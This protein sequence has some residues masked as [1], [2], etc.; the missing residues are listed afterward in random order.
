MQ[1]IRLEHL[2]NLSAS[3]KLFPR[4]KSGLCYQVLSEPNK[5]TEPHQIPKTRKK[6]NNHCKILKT[7]D[8]SVRLILI[9]T[10]T[11]R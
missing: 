8:S 2:E 3:T 11:K 4:G 1:C 10:R 9:N 7:H 5:T 6:F